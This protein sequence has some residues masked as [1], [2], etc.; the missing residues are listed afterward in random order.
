MRKCMPFG[1]PYWVRSGVCVFSASVVDFTSLE[2]HLHV[3]FVIRC[4]FRCDGAEFSEYAMIFLLSFK[5]FRL[6]G[7]QL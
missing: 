1:F 7:T 3:V 2:A 4:F 5:V 6:P